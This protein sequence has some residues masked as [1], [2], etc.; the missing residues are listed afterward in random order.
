[1]RYALIYSQQNVVTGAFGLSQEFAIRPAFQT[2]PLRRVRIVAGKA[3]P[4]I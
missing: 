2:G 3:M 4:E 1:M